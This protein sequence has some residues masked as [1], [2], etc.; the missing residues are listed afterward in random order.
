MRCL[1]PKGA[2]GVRGSTTPTLPG[3]TSRSPVDPLGA[4][5]SPLH[6]DQRSF[7]R[8]SGHLR[9]KGTAWPLAT[10]AQGLSRP[11]THDRCIDTGFD[12]SGDV[13]SPFGNPSTSG[14][15]HVG[16][17]AGPA[18]NLRGNVACWPPTVC[19]MAR[20]KREAPISYRPPKRMRDEF[21]SRVRESGL[22]ISGFITR[23]VFGARAPRAR[24]RS[25]LREE[26]VAQLL[27][28]AARLADLLGQAPQGSPAHT[29][30]LQEA[31]AELVE[32]RAALLA[33]LGREP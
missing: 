19:P 7:Q 9:A 11:W 14:L 22:S 1:R 20:K 17:R 31:R 15:K 23:A 25:A 4:T 33:L 12:Q 18:R 6:C 3:G 24:S 32:I 28:Q 2:Q 29:A 26:M 21:H 10:L 16:L 30:L 8:S 5:S 13:S 27:S